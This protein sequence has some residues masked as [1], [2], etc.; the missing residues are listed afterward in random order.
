MSNPNNASLKAEVNNYP[1]IHEVLV[2][3][4]H[5]LPSE[6][7]TLPIFY[8]LPSSASAASPVPLVVIICG[9]DGYRT[10]LAV[11]SEGFRRNDVAFAC[12]EVP[13]TGDSPADAKDSTSP[14]RL[15]S[16]LLDWVDAQE[17]IDSKRVV[18]WGFSTGGYY[19]IRVAHTHADRIAGS[20][21]IGG[22]CH[23]M[24]DAKWLSEVNHLEYPFE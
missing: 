10:E 5:A 16:S 14:D 21:S 8:Q 19:A 7:K 15:F 3:H 24:F 20:A 1:P 12:L 2:P 4:T 18:F 6:G 13:G 17:G 22:G 9:L 11:W 23:H